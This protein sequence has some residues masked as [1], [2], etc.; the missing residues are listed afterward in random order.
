MSITPQVS[1]YTSSPSHPEDGDNAFW[2]HLQNES[3]GLGGKENVT[4]ASAAIS[5][6]GHVPMA[7]GYNYLLLSVS[8]DRSTPAILVER[9]AVLLFL[10]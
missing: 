6:V 9:G 7:N 3:L 5:L 1:C 8:M 2:G 10:P 4:C